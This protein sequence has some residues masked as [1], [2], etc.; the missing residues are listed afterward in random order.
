MTRWLL[1]FGAYAL[2]SA[3]VTAIVLPTSSAALFTL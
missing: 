3:I 1:H 2:T